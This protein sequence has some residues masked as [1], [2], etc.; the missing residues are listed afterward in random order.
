V[1]INVEYEK[2][3]MLRLVVDDLRRKGI[4]A[5]PGCVPEYKG[6]LSVRLEID[7]TDDEAAVPSQSVESIDAAPVAPLEKTE[8]K[9]DNA[10]VD[11]TGIMAESRN[12]VMTQPGKFEPKPKRKLANSALSQESEEY[13]SED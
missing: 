12:L 5:K 10:P 3:D 11:M 7:V 9:K 6:A 4:K 8:K 2:A 13:P 1:R